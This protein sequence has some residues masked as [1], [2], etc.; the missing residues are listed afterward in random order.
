MDALNGELKDIKKR[1]KDL[2]H[3]LVELENEYD[4][5][6][7]N[8]EE[9]EDDMDDIYGPVTNARLRALAANPNALELLVTNEADKIIPILSTF[10]TESNIINYAYSKGETDK[11]RKYG[12][13]DDLY[14]VMTVKEWYNNDNH[15]CLKDN[16]FDLNPIYLSKRYKIELSNNSKDDFKLDLN[17]SQFGQIRINQYVTNWKVCN[18][19]FNCDL[20]QDQVITTDLEYKD[21]TLEDYYYL[22]NVCVYTVIHVKVNEMEED[23]VILLQPTEVGL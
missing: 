15:G 4:E 3:K 5:G 10:I 8:D 19:R 23:M 13:L 20:S 7:D 17:S 18:K 2:K 9:M 22:N 16:K 1:I 6:M 12:C 11:D 21:E 14:E